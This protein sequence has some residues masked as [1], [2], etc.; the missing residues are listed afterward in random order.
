M[1][2]PNWAEQVTAIATV[3]RGDRA[4]QR[5]R[6]RRC[7]PGSRC[8]RPGRADRHQIAVEF[9]R[10]WNEDALVEARRLAGPL[11]TRRVRS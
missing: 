2:G 1:S 7:L 9:F 11:R 8:R 4:A 5:A 3:R 10:R 6:R